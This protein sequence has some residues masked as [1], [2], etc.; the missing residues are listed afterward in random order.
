MTFLRALSFAS[1]LALAACAYRPP[2]FVDAPAVERV[3]DREPIPMPTPRR[4]MR[5]LHDANVYVRRELVRALDPR[6]ASDA[7]DVNALDEVPESAFFRRL[8]DLGR[9]LVGFRRDGAPVSPLRDRGVPPASEAPGARTIVD[10]RGLGY[11]L[12]PDEP[13]HR[14][15]MS[16]A[17]ATSSRLLHAIGYRVAEVHVVDL[18]GERFAA[19]RWP[20]GVDLG[21]TAAEGTRDDDPNDR[22]DHRDRRTLR[23]LRLA[24]AWLD[25]VDLEPRMLR[26]HYL[27]EPGEGHVE[28]TLIG[29]DGALGV[30]TLRAAEAWARDPDRADENFFFRMFTLGLSPIPRAKPPVAA[31]TSVGLLEPFVLP[32]SFSPSPPFS[33]SDRM[34]PADG[35]WL[36]KRVATIPS[37]VLR[38]AV[39]A[40]K[41]PPLEQNW[42][43]Q[44]LELRRAQ[45][46]AWAYDRVTPLD[47]GL[48]SPANPSRGL[49]A[50]LL[51]ADRAVLSRMTPAESSSYDVEFLDDEGAPLARKRGLACDRGIVTLPLGAELQAREYVVA[52]VTARRAGKA[53][54]RPVELH[55]RRRGEALALVGV[56]H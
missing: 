8:E 12:V 35:Y 14:G 11:E 37:R 52:E 48:L 13:N 56:R 7:G 3:A 27:G 19:T 45:I 24:A 46:V 28:H 26:D 50:R 5:A 40:S 23:S 38:R 47:P 9:P 15:R 42:L 22:L 41:L 1:C 20:V 18:E 55:F 25:I 4:L 31:F 39:L 16:G 32:G 10:A 36:A 49:E 29:I 33:P 2:R 6:G 21:P 17:A 54:P 34:T 30:G 43:L 51:L 44:M 53:L